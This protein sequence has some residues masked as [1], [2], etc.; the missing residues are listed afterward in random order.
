[1]FLFQVFILERTLFCIKKNGDLGTMPYY[2]SKIASLE[3]I[4]TLFNCISW[5]LT[6]HM[7]IWTKFVND[8]GGLLEY[9][10]SGMWSFGDLCIFGC[11]N[12]RRLLFLWFWGLAFCG[13]IKIT[14]SFPIFSLHFPTLNQNTETKTSTCDLLDTKRYCLLKFKRVIFGSHISLTGGQKKF[15]LENVVSPTKT[16]YL[17]MKKIWAGQY[18][19]TSNFAWFLQ[20]VTLNWL[21][22]F[23][24]SSRKHRILHDFGEIYLNLVILKVKLDNIPLLKK[25]TSDNVNDEWIHKRC[26]FQVVL[27][28][29]VSQG[30]GTSVLQQFRVF[31]FQNIYV[32]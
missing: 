14:G 15:S 25:W 29:S 32:P 19:K 31:Y 20:T 2:L 24:K 7:T 1:M 10:L 18:K 8:N 17:K 13:A 30:Q 11:K 9:L 22:L 4:W 12:I 21:L 27:I 3:K 5:C 6:D 23:L 26:N 28:F 16:T